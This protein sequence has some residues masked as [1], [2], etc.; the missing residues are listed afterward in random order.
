[1]DAISFVLGIKSSH[2]R[3]AH[4]RDLVY[5]GRVLRTSKINEDG[6]ATTNGVN[7]HMNGNGVEVEDEVD[8]TQERNDP[9]NAWV[10]AVYEDDA[11]DEQFWKRTITN[12]GASEYRISERV[13]TAQQYNEALEAENILIKARNFLV[14][15]GDVETIASQSPRDLTKL[16][17]QISGS[18]EYK[19]EYES[20]KDVQESALEHQNFALHRRRGINSEIKQYTDQKNEADSY[21][22]KADE[23]DQAVVTHILWKLYHF[24]R[25]I[26]ESGDAIQKHQEELKEQRRGIESYDK[27]LEEAKK[28]QAR[29]ARDVSKIEKSIKQKEKDVETKEAGLVPIAEKTGITQKNITKC[30]SR[31][32]DISKEKDNH[33]KTVKQLEKDL[34]VVD[35]AQSQWETEF[36]KLAEQ[37]GRELSEADLQLYNKLKEDVNKRTSAEQIKVDNF[38]RQQKADEE[39]VKSLKSTLDN[40]EW[41]T[42]KLGEELDE[43]N[44]RKSEINDQ[45]KQTTKDINAKKKTFN[46]RTSERLRSAQLRTEKDEKLQEVL[47]KLLE[48]EDGRKQNEKELRLKATISDLKRIFPGVKGRVSELC[49]PIEKRFQTAVSTVLG[50][51]FDS[52]I[53]ENEKT[54]IESIEYLRQQRR[55]QATFIPLDTIQF[56][57]PSSNLKNQHKGCRMALD[58]INYDR[59]L[60]RAMSY[61]CG[62]AVVCDDLKIAKYICWEKRNDVKAVTTDGSIIHKGGNMTGGQGGKQ[63]TRRWEDTEVENLHKLREKLQSELAS[64]PDTRRGTSEEEA[65]QGELAGLEQKLAYLK[66]E[67]KAHERNQASKQTALTHAKQELK[68]AKPKFEQKYREFQDLESAMKSYQDAVSQVQD[69]VFRDFCKRLSYKDIRAYEAQQGSVQQEGAQK[70]LEFATQKSRLESRISYEQQQL[71]ETKNRIKVLEQRANQD[72]ALI[73]ELEAEQESV[74]T[75][76]DK[77]SVEYDQLNEQLEREKMKHEQKAEKVAEARREVQKRS[78]NVDARLKAIADLEADRQLKASSRYT[79]LR[80]CKLEDINIPLEEDS[81]SLEFLPLDD[82]HQSDPDA[83]DVDEG[84]ITIQPSEVQDYG[85]EIDFDD[86]DEDL[87]EV[88]TYFPYPSIPSPIIHT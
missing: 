75:E 60:E 65:L 68:T 86:L 69:E 10:M 45:L 8:G 25:V 64:L 16:I 17:E 46:E 52:V 14:F 43:I 42:R 61:V 57:A 72:E 81:K 36:R 47:H 11:G 76:V 85:I 83:M 58:T 31:V 38:T 22:K 24:Q 15:Q 51:N 84:D 88:S 21:Q 6:S 33:T 19:A 12:Q 59:S 55:G 79:L 80:R 67:L 48:A 4:L 62:N 32:N 20:L 56:T 74:Q 9:K 53:V 77:L 1:M 7:G 13:V 26:E 82:I 41:Q 40:A 63:D 87:R 29:V 3:S 54:A 34:K 73:E 66:D 78:K 37:E 28:D 44:E 39:T 71:E 27:A 50:R 70:K 30:K 5:R 49:K 23:R 2:L 18:L 35:K